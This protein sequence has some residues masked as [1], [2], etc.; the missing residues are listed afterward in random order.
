MH[1]IRQMAASATQ[2]HHKLCEEMADTKSCVWINQLTHKWKS[3]EMN[4]QQW[5]SGK[6][7]WSQKKELESIGDTHCHQQSTIWWGTGRWE[8]VGCHVTDM[9]TTHWQN[10]VHCCCSQGPQQV[11][12]KWHEQQQQV[13]WVML[14]QLWFLG[15]NFVNDC[16]VM[17]VR[18]WFVQQQMSWSMV[19][20]M[21][22][23]SICCCELLCVSKPKS[24][25]TSQWATERTEQTNKQTNRA[26]QTKTK[27][28]TKTNKKHGLSW[29]HLHS[30]REKAHECQSQKP[31]ITFSGLHTVA[32]TKR[33]KIWLKLDDVAEVLTWS[34]SFSWF[35][36]DTQGQTNTHR[37]KFSSF[38]DVAWLGWL[39]LSHLGNVQLHIQIG[40]LVNDPA[41]SL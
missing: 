21:N 29:L 35:S 27:T 20:W 23:L 19:N 9:R 8:I 40:W 4:E 14:L 13:W 6:L 7:P 1:Q 12:L 22:E 39:L 33:A 17:V 32:S 41:T 10:F 15:W 30:S 26:K 28:K 34:L 25:L 16:C 37:S 38:C 18:R 3:E 2:A 11:L 24:Q 5:L 36:H 31:P